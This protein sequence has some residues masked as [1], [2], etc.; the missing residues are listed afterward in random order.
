MKRQAL[1]AAVSD[2]I[3]DLGPEVIHVRYSLEEDWSG[4]PSIFFRI[5]LS[6]DSTTDEKL[7]RTTQ[8]VSNHIEDRLEPMEEWGLLPYFDFR[9]NSEQDELKEKAWA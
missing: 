9:S 1:D 4:D 8:R 7:L 6:D 3:G 2:A 5:V